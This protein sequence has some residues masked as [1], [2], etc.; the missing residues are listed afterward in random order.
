[1]EKNDVDF[2]ELYEVLKGNTAILCLQKQ[3]CTSKVIKDFR[4]KQDKPV[5]KAAFIEENLFR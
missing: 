3:K 5:L 2:A 1:M 4:K